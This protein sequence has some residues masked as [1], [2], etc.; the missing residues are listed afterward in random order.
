MQHNYC[1]QCLHGQAYANRGT[2]ARIQDQ[3]VQV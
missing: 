2:F 3:I 1:T